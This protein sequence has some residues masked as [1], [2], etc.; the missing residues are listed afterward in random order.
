MTNQSLID[1]L[2][3]SANLVMGEGNE[4]TPIAVAEDLPFI[5]FVDR[6]PTTGE[7]DSLVIN[8]EDDLY[9]PILS[10]APWERRS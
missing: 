2:A 4:A 5:E 9:E 6:N 3:S 7:I 8:P 10:S 1:G